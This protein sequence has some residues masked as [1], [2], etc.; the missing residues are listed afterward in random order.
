MVA[1]NQLTGEMKICRLIDG[2]Q[3]KTPVADIEI[4]TPYFT[5]KCK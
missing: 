1:D 5:G 2:T 4:D 3:R